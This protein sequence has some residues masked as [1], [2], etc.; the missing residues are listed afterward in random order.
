MN[1]IDQYN[2]MLSLNNTDMNK[3]DRV[4]LYL[5]KAKIEFFYKDIHLATK[6][7]E[8]ALDNMIIN[9]ETFPDLF[10]LSILLNRLENLYDICCDEDKK[11]EL[12]DQSIY[13][14]ALFNS[15]FKWK[16]Y[17]EPI[18]I[19]LLSSKCE[20]NIEKSI[21]FYILAIAAPKNL[22]IDYLNMSYKMNSYNLATIDCMFKNKQYLSPNSLKDLFENKVKVFKIIEFNKTIE[23]ELDFNF[24]PLGGGD[25]IGCNSYF[26]NIGKYNILIDIGVK[27]DKKGNKYPDFELLEKTCSLDNLDMIILTHAHL[28]HCGAMVELYKRNPKIKI[29]MTKETREL[30]KINMRGSYIAL[31]DQHL[32]EECI[33]RSI[34]VPLREALNF[35]NGDIVLEL[36]RAG[37]ILGAASVLI[38]SKSCT[39]FFTGDYCL[40]DQHTILGLDIPKEYNIDIL[41]TENTYGKKTLS[42]ISNSRDFECEKLSTYVVNKI[43]EGKKILIPSFAIGRAQE[44]ICILKESAHKYN[45]RLYVD[46]LAVEVTELYKKYIDV[47]LYG[48]NV[49]YLK[50]IT[51]DNR[52]EFIEEEFMNN[53]SCVITSSGMLQ[54]GSTAISYAKKILADQSGICILTGYQADDTLGAKLKSQIDIDD[55]S[56]RYIQIENKTYKI[57]SEIK[58]FNLSAH[59]SNHEILALVASI[60]PKKV[61]LIHGD[62]KENESYIHKILSGNSKLDVYQS[63]NNEFIHL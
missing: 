50:N 61:I 44:L 20:D 63:R 9:N 17:D 59:C 7:F 16:K 33:K 47:D 51:Y 62:A 19:D 48:H 45:F 6:S 8:S 43:N 24:L 52:D 39:I 30:V 1:Y 18:D 10:I 14:N 5:A 31:N 15:Y 34:G 57:K 60:K 46:G 32:L 22:V 58:E 3:Q 28:D 53:R 54:E 25:D 23:S 21:L 38:K 37:H 29:I 26:L 2:Y 27:L 41:I 55:T 40:K 11:L 13:L 4:I 35:F 42:N 49:F 36:F 56:D 12:L